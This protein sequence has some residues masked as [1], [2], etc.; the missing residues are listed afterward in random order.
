MAA[1]KEMSDAWFAP[2]EQHVNR[3]PTVNAIPKWTN[4]VAMIGFHCHVFDQ[5][6]IVIYAGFILF[7]IAPGISQPW[8]LSLV[9]KKRKESSYAN[10]HLAPINLIPSREKR[11]E[12]K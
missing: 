8:L 6:G 1:L 4:A 2:S 12:K 5:R 10:C 9:L 7:L 3:K 11:V